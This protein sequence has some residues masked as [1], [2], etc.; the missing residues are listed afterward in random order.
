MILPTLLLLA[1]AAAVTPP[2][3]PPPASAVPSSPHSLQT[4]KASDRVT[5]APVVEYD[6]GEVPTIYTKIRYATAIVFPEPERIVDVVCGDKDWW[7]VAGP[8]RIVYV[9]PSKAGITT[10]LTVI[11]T[12]G[13]I[14]QFFLQ[15]ISRDP[16]TDQPIDATAPK[17]MTRRPYVRVSMVLPPHQVQQLAS[18]GPKYIPRAEYDT[19]VQEYQQQLQAAQAEVRATK[20]NARQ[21]IDQELSRI[22]TNYPAALEF[23][24]QIPLGVK[25]FFVAAMFSDDRFTY[26]KLESEEAPAVYEV[27]DGK[28]NLVNFDFVNGVFVVRK[29]I[30]Q[31][32]LAIGKAKLEFSRKGK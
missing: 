22:R 16:H 7:Q 17:D 13:N 21:V 24:Y 20:T 1:S 28:P 9:K 15:E 25:P 12:S 30:D 3:E 14:Y 26:I 32:Y 23:N 19:T 5:S 10:N 29:V 27:K 6:P 2:V 31:G 8:D 18:L 4:A 11:G